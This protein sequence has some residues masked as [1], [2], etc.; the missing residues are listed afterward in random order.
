MLLSESVWLHSQTSF[1]STSVLTLKPDDQKLFNIISCSAAVLASLIATAA[2]FRSA[3]VCGL[4]QILRFRWGVACDA[5]GVCTRTRLTFVVRLSSWARAGLGIFIV[6]WW[7][8]SDSA[9]VVGG[10][11]CW[12]L[13]W[14]ECF[15]VK[16]LMTHLNKQLSQTWNSSE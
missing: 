13:N 10:A 8:D 11:R 6:V 7:C 1:I 14:G 15:M 12:H 16:S 9:V 4:F 5:A 3:R 2:G